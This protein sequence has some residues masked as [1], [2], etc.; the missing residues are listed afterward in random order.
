MNKKT[1]V[2]FRKQLTSSRLAN[3]NE[4]RI[5]I[6]SLLI[7]IATLVCFHS[8][9]AQ[10]N[11]LSA[12]DVKNME[13][14]LKLQLPVTFDKKLHDELLQL[15]KKDSERV[16]DAIAERK[17]DDIMGRL[18]EARD[19]NG[20]S[21]CLLL[22]QHG[23][24]T[25]QLV[26]DDGAN[27]AFFL[28]RNTASAKMQSA[29]LPVI[30]AATS[31]GEI[32]LSEFAA[33]ID[34][35]RVSAGLKQLFGTQ[36]TIND[37]LLVMFP[38][39]NEALVDARRKQYQLGPLADYQR[40]LEQKYRLPLIKATGA[41]INQFSASQKKSI[42]KV[43]S[44]ALREGQEADEGDVLR[45]DTNLVSLYVSVYSNKL[46]A[47]VSTLQQK[48]FVVT[49]DG[50]RQEV[51]FF[52][53]TDV[54]FD[55]V[56]LI[57]LS[58]STSGKRKLI[59][60]TTQHFIEAA[61]PMDRLAIVTFSDVTE[62]VSPLT[63]DR[64]KLL[65]A[66]KHIDGGGASYVWDALKFTID[67]VLGP[68][69]LDRRRAVVFMTDGVDSA[70]GGIGVGSEISFADLVEAVRH[71]D[72]LIVPIY[73]DTEHDANG[74]HDWNGRL[75]MN[76]RRT[77]NLL[78]DESGG[79]YYK[80]KKIEDLSGIY[81]QVIQDLGKVYSLG[82]RSTRQQRDG[83]WRTVKVEITD[84]PELKARTRPGYYA[85]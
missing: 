74:A 31:Q 15:S 37:G 53:A 49:E 32:T 24:P 76:A 34:R 41:L 33:Y 18:Q 7:L 68:K 22:K 10:D 13:A 17:P 46:Q 60:Q 55:L 79:L 84:R 70:L 2:V 35:V 6:R 39:E 56:L 57:D 82:Y 19:K 63:T 67:K 75:Y 77:L 73:L 27:A 8:A 50:A 48:D 69:T 58:G 45:V 83:T 29:L 28:L 12:D 42:D 81:E 25:R 14:G 62:I 5:R 43:T 85:N 61:R 71:S 3:M 40:M 64:A 36:A 21:L 47:Q 51:S 38:I 52:A 66:A 78:A 11:C 65:E 4:H 23:W 59:R 16:R 44:A 80:A 9:P 20:D 72:A 26:G 30:V 1:V 54:P